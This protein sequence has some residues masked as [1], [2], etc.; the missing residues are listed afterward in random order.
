[1]STARHQE[2]EE[3]SWTIRNQHDEATMTLHNST[4]VISIWSSSL[5]VVAVEVVWKKKKKKYKW[6][7]V[8]LLF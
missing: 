5:F 6:K 2:M 8:Y 3:I 1:M 4:S 7:L